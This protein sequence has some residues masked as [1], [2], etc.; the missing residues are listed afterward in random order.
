MLFRRTDPDLHALDTLLSRES[1]A[2]DAGD[3]RALAAMTSEKET[4][5]DRLDARAEELLASAETDPQMRD[6]LETTRT[7]MTRNGRRLAHVAETVR[8]MA[9]TLKR[10]S[11]RHGLGGLYGADGSLGSAHAPKGLLDREV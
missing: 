9:N 7:Q 2:L 8:G 10:I 4:L 3:T 6:R 5:L 1:A 11:G